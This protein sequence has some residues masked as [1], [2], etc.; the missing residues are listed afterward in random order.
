MI[1]LMNENHLQF[2]HLKGL[3]AINCISNYMVNE[4]NDWSH[5]VI[6]I[7]TRHFT[8]HGYLHD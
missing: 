8:C 6:I 7:T 1:D 3:I 5:V 2:I 4:K